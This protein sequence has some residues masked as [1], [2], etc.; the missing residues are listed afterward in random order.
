MAGITLRVLFGDVYIALTIV[1]VHGVL[2][3]VGFQCQRVNNVRNF[4]LEHLTEEELC[5]K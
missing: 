5:L 2:T 3:V 1:A 4:Q